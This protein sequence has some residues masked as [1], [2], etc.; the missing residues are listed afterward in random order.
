MA[1]DLVVRNR[2]TA[3]SR[4]DAFAEVG[5]KLFKVGVRLSLV[6]VLR[7]P[8]IRPHCPLVCKR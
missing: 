5:L 4:L 2:L 1:P 7:I 3:I 8:Q 6:H